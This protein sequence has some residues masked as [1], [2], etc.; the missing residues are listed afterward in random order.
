MKIYEK[1]L[2]NYFQTSFTEDEDE[3][4]SDW[5]KWCKII[6]DNHLE[7]ELCYETDAE[8]SCIIWIDDSL[9]LMYRILVAGYYFNEPEGLKPNEPFLVIDTYY[10]CEEEKVPIR[11]GNPLSWGWTGELSEWR[12][13]PE[14][15]L[16]LRGIGA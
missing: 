7:N 4:G 14:Q 12:F 13:T 3:R 9:A 2:S 15:A 10:N 5:E 1:E 11:L 6:K 8:V 16:K